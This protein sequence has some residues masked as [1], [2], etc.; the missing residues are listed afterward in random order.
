MET[1][2]AFV[3][4]YLAIGAAC[5]SHPRSPAQPNDFHWRSQVSVFRGTLP[6]VLCWPLALWRFALAGRR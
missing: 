3:L 6:E 2:F 1:V 4:M 5:F